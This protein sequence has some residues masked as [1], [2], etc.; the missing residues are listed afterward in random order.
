MKIMTIVMQ[1][2]HT[3]ISVARCVRTSLIVAGMKTMM[4]S[5][6]KIV[7]ENRYGTAT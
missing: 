4:M 1:Q 3:K 2:E 6:L 5:L 7:E